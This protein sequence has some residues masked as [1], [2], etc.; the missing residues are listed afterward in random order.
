MFF[1]NLC[2]LV[3]CTKVASALEGLIVSFMSSVLYQLVVS[4][5]WNNNILLSFIFTIM[6]FISKTTNMNKIHFT[7]LEDVVHDCENESR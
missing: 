7:C 3:L 4:L 2:A 5:N 1:K 6:N